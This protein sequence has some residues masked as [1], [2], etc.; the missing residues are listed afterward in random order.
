MTD[1]KDLEED[2]DSDILADDQTEQVV[3]VIRID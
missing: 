3:E 1:Y 2:V